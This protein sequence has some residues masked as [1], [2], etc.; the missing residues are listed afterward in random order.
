MSRNEVFS[1]VRGA[2]VVVV[3]TS[4]EHNGGMADDGIM[5]GQAYDALGIGTPLLLL[6]PPGSDIEDILETAGLGKSFS[7]NNISGIADF[8]ADALKGKTPGPKNPQAYSWL[9]IIGRLD[10]V[11]RDGIAHRRHERCA[12]LPE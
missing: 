5:T 11:L 12:A 6:A 2:K 8:L 4:A 10:R 1:A 9:Q 3:I 7:G